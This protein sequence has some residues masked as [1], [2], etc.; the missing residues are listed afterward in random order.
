VMG[1]R[2]QSRKGSGTSGV[3]NGSILFLLNRSESFL[4]AER[5]RNI[6]SI[7]ENHLELLRYIH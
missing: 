4:R 6:N 3:G 7:T 5:I 1:H 2:V